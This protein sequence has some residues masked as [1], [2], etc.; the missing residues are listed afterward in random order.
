M[1]PDSRQIR[2]CEYLPDVGVRFGALRPAQYATPDLE[3]K[4]GNCCCSSGQ[5]CEAANSEIGDCIYS[6][7]TAL[8][9]TGRAGRCGDLSP[10]HSCSTQRICV[11]TRLG[12]ETVSNC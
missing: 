7:G 1:V 6:L 4:R 8:A 9:A 10:S 3:A 11:Q 12:V 2:R 5:N